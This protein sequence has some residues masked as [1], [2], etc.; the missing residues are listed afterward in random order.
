MAHATDIVGYTWQADLL[1]PTCVPKHFPYTGA[2]AEEVLDNGATWE[3]VD[4]TDESSFDSS[5]FGDWGE[6][7]D[8]VFPKVV[9]RSML[10]GTE[11]CG[12]CGETLGE[13]RTGTD[14][15]PHPTYDPPLNP[16]EDPK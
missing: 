13:G 14:T 16:K 6:P 3:G 1:C 15:L 2:T 12:D 4:R 9:F 8:L 10:D 5:T 7:N 11:A